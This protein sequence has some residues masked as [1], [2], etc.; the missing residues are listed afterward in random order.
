MQA[1]TSPP[2]AR[3]VPPPGADPL[4][5]YRPK[6]RRQRELVGPKLEDVLGTTLRPELLRP[7]HAA[8]EQLHR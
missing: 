6:A 5:A 2:D 7:L 4:S 3:E 8:V 1:A